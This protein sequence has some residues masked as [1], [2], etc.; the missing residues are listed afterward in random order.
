MRSLTGLSVRGVRRRP[1]RF[2][3]TGAGIALGVAVLFAVLTVEAV[4]AGVLGYFFLSGVVA[5]IAI[6][7]R[8]GRRRPGFR[9]IAG[10]LPWLN[11]IVVD[12]IVSAGT[13]IGLQLLVIPGLVFA[14]WYGLAAVLVE[15]RDLTPRPALTRS[16][17][18]TCGKRC[19]SCGRWA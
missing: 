2:A 16:R 13:A 18:R 19:A 1:G 4:A 11:L 12:L 7:R 8:R 10:T 9:E 3:L 14:T 5:Q 15:T 6:A 17:V